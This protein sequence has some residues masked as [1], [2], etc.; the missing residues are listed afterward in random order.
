MDSG[1][2]ASIVE[3]SGCLST[4]RSIGGEGYE[5]GRLVAGSGGDSNIEGD[6]E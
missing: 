6:G 5:R 1:G 4:F 2:D 3:V